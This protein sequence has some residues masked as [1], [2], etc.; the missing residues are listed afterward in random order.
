MRSAARPSR[1]EF[2]GVNYYPFHIGDYSAHTA[3]LEPMEDL[4]YRRMLDLYYRTEC[5]LP[6][7]VEDIARLI[8][9]KDEKAAIRDVLNEFFSQSEEGWRHGRCDEEIS[10]A[11]DK[12][13]KAAKSAAK[14]WESERSA[15]AM[16]T[17][18]EGNAPN[19]NP[20]PKEDI[21]PTVLVDTASPRQPACP[22][23]E[24]VSLYHKHLP[25]LPRV[26]VMN[27]GRRKSIAARWKEVISD[28][29]IRK[30]DDIRAAA[31]EW[32]DWYFSHAARSKFLT[33]RDKD[34]RADFDFLVTQS[35]FAKVVEGSYHNES[36]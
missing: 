17:H 22:V 23:S 11:Q 8:R 25:M 12:R 26:E 6:V 1:R 2:T 32:F 14:R 30:S 33:G 35:K 34:W 10:T 4:A 3:H 31:L 29:D 36:T 5:P 9:L 27:A 7:S 20:N 13:S 18:S 19:P 28:P 16:R 21:E 24:L 15:N